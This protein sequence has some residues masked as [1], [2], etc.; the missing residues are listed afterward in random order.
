MYSSLN[1]ACVLLIVIIRM[2]KFVS[3]AL[4]AFALVL[5][6]E[7]KDND[8]PEDKDKDKYEYK[9][10]YN[11]PVSVPDNGSTALLLGTALLVLGLAGR[12]MAIH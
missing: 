8:K 5:N 10:K 2:K 3:C 4:V 12:R 9:D 1:M 11:S 7:A 6:A